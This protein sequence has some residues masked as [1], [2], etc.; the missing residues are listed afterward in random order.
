MCIIDL[1]NVLQSLPCKDYWTR[2]KTLSV[3]NARREM[4]LLVVINTWKLWRVILYDWQFDKIVLFPVNWTFSLN[5]KKIIKSWSMMILTDLSN[6]DFYYFRQTIKKQCSAKL[7]NT[8][9]KWR[10]KTEIIWFGNSWDQNS[11]SRSLDIWCL[12]GWF[13]LSES[14]N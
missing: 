13:F 3:N 4:C 14:N 5:H 2:M 1:Q 11:R 10:Q 12:K 6:H 7:E 8:L 9:K